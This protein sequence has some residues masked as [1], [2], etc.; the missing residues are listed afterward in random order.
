MVSTWLSLIWRWPIPVEFVYNYLSQDV[1]S[2]TNKSARASSLSSSQ[3]V[4]HFSLTNLTSYLIWFAGSTLMSCR[5]ETVTCDWGK[6]QQTFKWRVS[7]QQNLADVKSRTI[8]LKP[9]QNSSTITIIWIWRPVRSLS[10]W[11]TL[12][13]RGHKLI[14]LI[15]CDA[16]I[17]RIIVT[18]TILKYTNKINCL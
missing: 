17:D 6:C 12:I 9:T 7:D 1:K 3:P 18:K 15:C 16:V 13:D 10:L 8:R 14:S 5:Y 11:S 4:E 2:A